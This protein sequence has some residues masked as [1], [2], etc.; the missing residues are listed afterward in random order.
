MSKPPRFA[1][2][3]RLEQA[4]KCLDDVEHLVGLDPNLHMDDVDRRLRRLRLR[5]RI[6]A[7]AEPTETRSGGGITGLPGHI[8]R[9]GVRIH[10][11]ESEQA[12]NTEAIDRTQRAKQLA[13]KI[14]HRHRRAIDLDPTLCRIWRDGNF[15]IALLCL[16][17]GRSDVEVI[18]VSKL[19]PGD[20]D[21]PSVGEDLAI[22]RAL[23]KC[24]RPLLGCPR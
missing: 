1:D 4:K 22:R 21:R 23:L 3:P 2:L 6:L 17:K 12:M 14:N 8:Q 13:A 20:V 5:L 10:G 9:P 7:S 18:A 16:G 11:Q 24:A 15:T 19:N